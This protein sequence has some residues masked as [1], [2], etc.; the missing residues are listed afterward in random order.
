MFENFDDLFDEFFKGLSSRTR[1]PDKRLNELFTDLRK[2][3]ES[4]LEEDKMD[5]LVN[6]LNRFS[7]LNGDDII[8]PHEKDLGEPDEV[9]TFEQDGYIFEKKIW[10]L[11]HGQMVKVNMVLTPYDSD[12][13]PDI[14]TLPLEQR[15]QIALDEERY[16]EAAKIRDEIEK[17][18]NEVKP[19]ETKQDEDDEWNF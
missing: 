7:E 13:E 6:K 10:N 15:L 19:Q 17:K 12:Y 4:K 3:I 2:E 9:V 11:K 16:E 8:N 14:K 18:K 5:D 1:K